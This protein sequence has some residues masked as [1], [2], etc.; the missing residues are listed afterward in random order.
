M[1]TSTTTQLF[2]L[3]RIFQTFTISSSPFR[4]HRLSHH[5]NWQNN[6]HLTAISPDFLS[7]FLDLAHPILHQIRRFHYFSRIRIL[8]PSL[9]DSKLNL[10]PP[11]QMIPEPLRKLICSSPISK[12]KFSSF[13]SHQAQRHHHQSKGHCRSQGAV[14][15]AFILSEYCPREGLES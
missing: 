11:V 15:G 6:Q 10:K 4:L 3:I 2:P 7:P 5:N 8:T 14:Q 12:M 9:P 13:Q 1:S